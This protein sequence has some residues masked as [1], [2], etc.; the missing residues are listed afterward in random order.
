MTLDRRIQTNK[1]QDQ[2]GKDRYTTEI[3]GREM[4]M[5][6]SRQG[7]EGMSSPRGG[8]TTTQA[9]EAGAPTAMEPAF[10]DDIPF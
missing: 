7:S 1:C 8:F 6:D 10:D 5:L 9:P 4:Q 3:I 2:E